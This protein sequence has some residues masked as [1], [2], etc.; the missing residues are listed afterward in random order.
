VWYEPGRGSHGYGCYQGGTGSASHTRGG[1]TGGESQIEVFVSSN[2]SSFIGE[3]FHAVRVGTRKPTG[4]GLV[5][6]ILVYANQF[7]L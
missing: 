7:P 4:G 2:E 1:S 5:H 6:K 3:S